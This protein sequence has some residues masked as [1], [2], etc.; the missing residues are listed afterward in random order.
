MN[1]ITPL[2]AYFALIVVFAQKY[3]AKAGVGTLVALM[4]PYVIAIYVVWTLLFVA[5]FLLGL[6]WGL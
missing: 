3:D 5:W 2:N 1:V 4:I 6:P